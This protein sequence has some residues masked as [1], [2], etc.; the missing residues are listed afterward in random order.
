MWYS[1]QTRHKIR[2]YYAVSRILFNSLN[3]LSVKSQRRFWDVSK[4]FMTYK[5][6]LKNATVTHASNQSKNNCAIKS[7]GQH[8]E[9]QHKNKTKK[10]SSERE[11][12]T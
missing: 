1:P 7:E 3:C 12:E 4:T 2:I 5:R 6:R 11:G 9:I 10:I 8:V